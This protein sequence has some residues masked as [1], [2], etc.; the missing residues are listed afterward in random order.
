MNLKLRSLFDR[1]KGLPE[2]PSRHNSKSGY[3]LIALLE[4]KTI[5]RSEKYACFTNDAHDKVWIERLKTIQSN[6]WVSF[7]DLEVIDNEE[8]FQSVS[9]FLSEKN[10]LDEQAL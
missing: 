8:E 4:S 3:Y 7:E 9:K 2:I 10:I 6:M 1:K 5:Y